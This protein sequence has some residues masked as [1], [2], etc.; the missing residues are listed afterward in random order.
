[1]AILIP[2]EGAKPFVDMLTA[3]GMPTGCRKC[4]ITLEIGSPIMLDCE[5]FADGKTSPDSLELVKKKYVLVERKEK[6]NLKT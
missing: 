5:L 2:S 1:M 6:A 4:V 3:I